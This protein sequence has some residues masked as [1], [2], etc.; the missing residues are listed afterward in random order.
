MIKTAPFNITKIKPGMILISGD[1]FIV[2]EHEHKTTQEKVF[3]TLLKWNGRVLK[4]VCQQTQTY[5][6]VV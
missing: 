6:C 1:S 5:C 3:I 4:M 2:L